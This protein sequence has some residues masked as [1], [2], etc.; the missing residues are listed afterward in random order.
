MSCGNASGLGE[1]VGTWTNGGEN[2]FAG[3]CTHATYCPTDLDA[4]DGAD[5]TLNLANRGAAKPES[6]A[7]D[8][9]P[10]AD[11]GILRRA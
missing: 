9:G 3:D 4:V 11:S 5:L 10:T 2:L 7:A 1:V 6:L 8:S